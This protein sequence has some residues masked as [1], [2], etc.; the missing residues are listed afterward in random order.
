MSQTKK[1]K[2]TKQPRQPDTQYQKLLQEILDKDVRTKTQ[3]EVDA[4]TLIGPR[5]LHFKIADGFPIITERNMAPK[6]SER[7]LV[8]IWQQA[9]AEII[10]FMNG[11]RTLEQLE[12]APATEGGE[13]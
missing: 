6:I 11:A 3:Q 8:T 1:T 12:S 13:S 4:I 2:T 5:P 10:G 7:L 9:I